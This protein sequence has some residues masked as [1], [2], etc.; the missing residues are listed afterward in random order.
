[1][2]S[3]LQGIS[4]EIKWMIDIIEE[5]YNLNDENIGDILKKISNL[6]SNFGIVTENYTSYIK[7]IIKK[8]AI[9]RPSKQTKFLNLLNSLNLDENL[10]KIEISHIKYDDIIKDENDLKKFLENFQLENL[11]KCYKFSYYE[12][13]NLS[14]IDLAALY[15]SEKAFKYGVLNGLKPT[16]LTLK[17]SIMGGNINILLDVIKYLEETNQFDK[18]K[19][20][21]YAALY[22]R[23]DIIDLLL[24]KYDDIDITQIEKENLLY[25]PLL[26]FYISVKTSNDDIITIKNMHFQ[27]LLMSLQCLNPTLLDENDIQLIPKKDYC[28]SLYYILKYIFQFPDDKANFIF[29]NIFQAYKQYIIDNQFNETQSNFSEYISKIRNYLDNDMFEIIKAHF[30][31]VVNDN[32]VKIKGPYWSFYEKALLLYHYSK[33]GIVKDEPM[34]KINKTKSAGQIMI[35]RLRNHF[36]QKENSKKTDKQNKESSKENDKQNEENKENE[37]IS[38]LKSLHQNIKLLITSCNGMIDKIEKAFES[39]EI[40]KQYMKT[41]G[42]KDKPEYFIQD[43]LEACL[44]LG[45]TVDS[46]TTLKDLLKETE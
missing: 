1:M 17:Y 27:G 5:I 40:C 15:A 11:Q 12:K 34:I 9:I 38:K 6:N 26:T 30:D 20:I 21:N 23:N 29:T 37:A 33:D 22:I 28:D 45:I 2:E 36:A 10:K 42:R 3:F 14:F 18:N 35:N 13:V 41:L 39:E 7:D 46:L 44:A 43:L 16:D 4:S 19:C 24:S 31:I 8:A 32:F 25:N